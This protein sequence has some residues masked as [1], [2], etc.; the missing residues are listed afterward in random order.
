[1]SCA[2]NS[3][4]AHGRPSISLRCWPASHMARF[5]ILKSSDGCGQTRRST[6]W[7]GLTEQ[8]SIPR[9]FTTGRW[10]WKNSPHARVHGLR[11]QHSGELPSRGIPSYGVVAPDLPDD[12]PDVL[13]FIRAGG[14]AEDRGPHSTHANTLHGVA[15]SA[16]AA[17][18]RR[19]PCSSA[20]S[21]AEVIVP[22]RIPAA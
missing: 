17:D 10:S 2:W 6:R 3:P 8:T 5:K 21:G 1:M 18:P 13:S 9:R 20:G 12:R 11:R 15:Y 7:C 14:F 16:V 19:I 4:T 22:V